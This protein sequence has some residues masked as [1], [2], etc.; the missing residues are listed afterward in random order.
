MAV[1]S[2]IYRVGSTI[3]TTIV[4]YKVNGDAADTAEG[5][6]DLFKDSFDSIYDAQYAQNKLTVISSK[7]SKACEKVLDNIDLPENRK[8]ILLQNLIIAYMKL[9][10]DFSIIINSVGD[11]NTLSKKLIE[12]NQQ[13]RD[14]LNENEYKYYYMLIKHM[15]YFTINAFLLLPDFSANGI[16]IINEKTNQ[17]QRE[18]ERLV[19]E[20]ETLSNNTYNHFESNYRRALINKL[21]FVNVYGFSNAIT[22][23]SY[24]DLDTSYINLKFDFDDNTIFQNI[25]T[26]TNTD[27]FSDRKLNNFKNIWISGSPGSGKTTYLQHLAIRIAKNE[28]SIFGKKDL[29]PVLITVRTLKEYSLKRCIEKYLDNLDYSIPDGWIT[30]CN[31]ERRFIYLLDGLD[32]V[33]SSIRK[34]IF[35]WIRELDPDNGCIKVYTARPQVKDEENSQFKRLKQKLFLHICPMSVHQ[36][37]EFI[38]K[39]HRAVLENEL[40]NLVGSSKAMGLALFNKIILSEPLLKLG[41]NPLLCA[42]ICSINHLNNGNI[43][44]SKMELYKECVITLL[45][46]RDY[47]RDINIDKISLRL[48]QKLLIFAKLAYWMMLNGHFAEVSYN[49]AVKQIDYY[50]TEMGIK[51]N[52]EDILRYFLN[53]SG[54]IRVPEYGRIEFAHRSFLEYLCALQIQRENNWGFICEKIE[55]DNWRETIIDAIN[56]ANKQTAT[57][58]IERVLCKCRNNPN[59]TNE[60]NKYWFFAFSLLNS[61][62]E[63]E[64]SVR[65]EINRY[66]TKLIPPQRGTETRVA[67]E[68]QGLAI[69]YL[70]NKNYNSDE[71]L[72]CIKTLRYIGGDE[73]L[74]SIITYIDNDLTFDETRIMCELF[75]ECD[76]EAIK[77]FDV[78]SIM[79]DALKKHKGS[80]LI[81]NTILDMINNSSEDAID[82]FFD[83][84]TSVIYDAEINFQYDEYSDEELLQTHVLPDSYIFKSAQTLIINGGEEVDLSIIR[85][86]PN[87]SDL[88]IGSNVSISS[89]NRYYHNDTSKLKTIVMVMNSTDFVDFSKVL[90]VKNC[91]DVEFLLLNR[92]DEIKL[93]TIENIEMNGNLQIG[94]CNEDCKLDRILNDYMDYLVNTKIGGTFTICTNNKKVLG[95]RKSNKLAFANLSK[96]IEDLIKL[97]MKIDL[98]NSTVDD[99]YNQYAIDMDEYEMLISRKW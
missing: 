50:K 83:S 35:N 60:I 84:I 79:V 16:L 85:N 70:S 69:P 5:F 31:N 41:S 89:L 25:D 24:Y 66:I 43:P 58:I 80:I 49:E 21:R 87:I 56:L 73:C 17:I 10:P 22:E 74:R 3:L 32:E 62:M 40:D 42:M 94:L 2:L 44:N 53:R 61:A 57:E 11:V 71:R 37:R 95:I 77:A 12:S 27:W 93:E 54:L 51:E 36:I 82:G 55:S 99:E 33:S 39:W 98:Q 63:V 48:E 18:L 19:K 91:V 34:D 23:Y 9:A 28:I 67:N 64:P 38:L 88:Y 6:F 15:A 4:R 20:V 7:A 76:P 96:E 97:G 26:T 46:K 81:N 78:P 72:A 47:Q 14:D 8:E 59:N 65:R 75:N 90:Y 1:A 52:A 45:D 13:F 92:I 30:S 29:I 86:F 68:I